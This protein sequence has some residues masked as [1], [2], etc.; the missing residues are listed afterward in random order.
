M[1]V[2]LMVASCSGGGSSSDAGSCATGG[3]DVQ[4][5]WRNRS[6]GALFIVTDASDKTEIPA[7][8]GVTATTGTAAVTDSTRITWTLGDGSTMAGD[9]DA[10]CAEVIEGQMTNTA[11]NTGVFTATRLGKS[12]GVT[13]LPDG[14]FSK[15][16]QDCASVCGVLRCA[17]GDGSGQYALT[18][19]DTSGCT[20]GIANC[21]GELTCGECSARSKSDGCTANVDC[22]SCERCELSTGRCVARLS[23]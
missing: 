1:I 21:Y 16:C 17:C 13:P 23:C 10:K 3:W 7:G 6:P 14:S 22:G 18:Q 15:T 4:F 9:A 12:C 11:G 2:S 5:K 8:P 19:L 20:Q